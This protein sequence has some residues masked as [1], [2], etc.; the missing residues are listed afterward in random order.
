MVRRSY[1]TAAQVIMSSTRQIMFLAWS[2]VPRESVVEST[3]IYSN[4]RGGDGERLYYN[5]CSSICLNGEFLA[6][7]EQFSLQ[8]VVRIVLAWISFRHLAF[9]IFISANSWLSFF[10]GSLYCR[11]WFRG[12]SNVSKLSPKSRHM[13]K[14]TFFKLLSRKLHLCFVS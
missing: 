1:A 10:A 5:G 14:F 7:A 13:C 4:L 2:K 3:Y 9:F 6:R 8:E 11:C 12:Y